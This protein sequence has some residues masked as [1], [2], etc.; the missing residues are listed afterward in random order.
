MYFITSFSKLFHLVIISSYQSKQKS[1][2]INCSLFTNSFLLKDLRN[3]KGNCLVLNFFFLQRQITIQMILFSNRIIEG[4]YFEVHFM[5]DLWFS[6]MQ[7]ER[8]C[9]KFFDFERNGLD[10][11]KRKKI[12]NCFLFI[13]IVRSINHLNKE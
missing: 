5:S 8:I 13:N 11:E 1:R 3:L 6:L 9:L 7:F 2:L 10:S 12:T 4:L